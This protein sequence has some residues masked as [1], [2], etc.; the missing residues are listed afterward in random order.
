ME[1]DTLGNNGNAVL[2]WC[3]EHCSC[4]EVNNCERCKHLLSTCR[5]RIFAELSQVSDSLESVLAHRGFAFELC[6]RYNSASTARDIIALERL[7]NISLEEF[8]PALNEMKR[9]LP[10]RNATT[11]AVPKSDKDCKVHETRSFAST[12]SNSPAVHHNTETEASLCAQNSKRITELEQRLLLLEQII[13]KQT[14]TITYL[15]SSKNP[16]ADDVQTPETERTN[17]D[18]V[19]SR[20]SSRVRTAMYN[21]DQCMRTS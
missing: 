11:C 16:A 17:S 9:Q 12:H 13:A 20:R 6:R 10:F 5:Q 19:G 21:D 1:S 4:T 14:E 7:R 18:I 2:Q 3:L 8:D 15:L